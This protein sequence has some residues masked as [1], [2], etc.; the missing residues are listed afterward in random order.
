MSLGGKLIDEGLSVM[1][2]QV[3]R[4]P[5]P[6]NQQLALPSSLGVFGAGDIYGNVDKLGVSSLQVTADRILLTNL[7]I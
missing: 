6:R 1:M 4:L 3:L 5:G 7:Q 2:I